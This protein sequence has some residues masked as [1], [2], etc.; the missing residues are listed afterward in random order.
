MVDGRDVD[1]NEDEGRTIPAQ[2]AARVRGH[3]E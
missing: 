3:G 1:S 2:L